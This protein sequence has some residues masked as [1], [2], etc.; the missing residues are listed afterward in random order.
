MKSVV[1]LDHRDVIVPQAT[2]PELRP[3]KK[4][5]LADVFPHIPQEPAELSNLVFLDGSF[6]CKG[7]QFNFAKRRLQGVDLPRD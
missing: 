1:T 7:S 4:L 6:S 2:F 3:F 5:L